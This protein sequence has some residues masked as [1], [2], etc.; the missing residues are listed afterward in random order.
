MKNL[1]ILLTLFAFT[2][3]SNAQSWK[4]SSGG[5]AFDGKYRTSS[6]RGSGGDF[7]YENPT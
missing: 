4:K 6:V 5:D 7:P 1:L 2:L 3:Q